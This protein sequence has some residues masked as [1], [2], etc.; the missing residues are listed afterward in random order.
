MNT[1]PGRRRI[2]LG[3]LCAACLRKYVPSMVSCIVLARRQEHYNNLVYGSSGYEWYLWFAFSR[4][5]GYNYT[6]TLNHG[7]RFTSARASSA[8]PERGGG[9][10]PESAV[11]DRS[12]LPRQR[13]LRSERPG[14]GQVRDAPQRP[15]GGPCSGGGGPSFWP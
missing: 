8:G 1:W 11:C 7:H 4:V 13:V 5:V 12:P 3:E 14:A 9:H 10:P 2:M 6:D 15:E